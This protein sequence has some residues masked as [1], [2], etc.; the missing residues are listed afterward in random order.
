MKGIALETIAYFMIALATIVLIFSLIG[1]KITP[2]I[3]NAYCSFVRGIRLIMPLP[4]YMRP[5][6]PTY[7]EKNVTVYLETKF[8]ESDDPGRIEFL[9]ASYVI[10][11]W[12]RTGKLEVG[13][14]ILCYEIVMKNP[15][16][17]PVSSGNVA[18]Y[19]DDVYQNIM[20][21]RT[22]DPI[23]QAK[24]IGITYDSTNKEIE[25]V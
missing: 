2:A 1:T 9:I 16:R 7:C 22:D 12:E 5:P 15:P 19:V 11:C 4:S 14:N 20:N 23:N 10:A 17:G 13:Q 18:T 8:I 25:V 24:S 6:L 21:W 3:R